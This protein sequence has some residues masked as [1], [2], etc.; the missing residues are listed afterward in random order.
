MKKT[1]V[2]SRMSGTMFSRANLRQSWKLSS[3][4]RASASGSENVHEYLYSSPESLL[5]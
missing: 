4:L 1:E 2:Q 5:N 3:F